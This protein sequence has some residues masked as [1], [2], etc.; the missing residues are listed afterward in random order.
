MR[1][2]SLRGARLVR[3]LTPLLMAASFFLLL[4]VLVP[5]IGMSANGAQRWIGAGLFQIQPSELAKLSLVLY[6][7][8]LLAARPQM[9]RDIR[10]LVPYLLPVALACLL[11]V[12]EPD[13]GTAIVVCL[14][15]GAMLVAAGVKIRHL[16]L[17]AGAIG[18]VLL[19]AIVIEPYRMQR[20]TGFIHPTGDPGGAG[21]QAIQAKIALGSGGIFGVGLGQ[22]LQKAFYLP[23]AHTDMIAAVIG[24]ELGL[25]GL[26]MLV[27]LFGLFGYAG[28]RTAQRARD[29]YGKLLAAGL[30]SLILVQAI[31]NLFAVLGL[32]PA[33]GR[34]AA[35]RL[36]RQLEP[37]GDAGG[38]RA[39]PEH[40]PRGPGCHG[41][42]ERP[43]RCETAGRRRRPRANAQRRQARH[44]KERFAAVPR[45]VIA[46]G[47]TAGHVVPALAVADALRGRG[48]EVSFL[49]ARGRLEAELVPA[50]GYEIDFL[51]VRGLDR[52]APL[53]AAA[54]AALAA[55][56]VPAARTALR[57]RQAEAVMGGG[58]YVAGPAGL[59]ALS[60][61][62]PLVLTEAD[63]HLGLA[64]RLLARGARRV[65]LAFPI[66]G[67]DEGRYMV[68]GRPVPA[69]I[70]AAD[71]EGA[72]RRFQ[73]RAGRPL[74]AR[75]RRQPGRPLDQPLR[76]R[77]LRRGR[78]RGLSARLPRHPDRGPPRLP[79]GPAAAER[80]RRGRAIHAAR[81]R[82]DARR[83]ACRLRPR[84]RPGGRLGVRARGRGQAGDP[85]PLPARDGA[86]PR[87]QRG[88]DV[89]GGRGAGDRRLPARSGHPASNG[90]GPVRGPRSPGEDVRGLPGS[91]PAGRRGAHRRAGARRG[92]AA[93]SG[94][95]AAGDEHRAMTDWSRRKLH[96]IAIGGAGMSGLALVCHRLG[97]R[98]SGSR[99]RPELLPR[100]PDG[101]QAS[102]RGLVTTPTTCR[103]TPRWWS[104]PPFREDNPELARAR[105]RG[106][107]VIHRGELLAELCATKRLLAIAGTHGKTTTAGMLVHA[108]RAIGRRPVLSA[109]RRAAGRRRGWRSRQRRLGRGAS[110]WS[111]RRTSPTRASCAC[112]RRSRW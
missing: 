50:A 75:V 66:P 67:R 105:E 99:S 77:R 63:R 48:A 104:R 47:G 6:G 58:G 27:G 68:T 22:S 5:G 40:R 95:R 26:S 78:R 110:G 55:A 23:E 76:A 84:A 49:G 103:R 80:R 9:T 24:E 16:M 51:R 70:L 20:L 29:R 33:D 102:S 52:R 13:L 12:A 15:T 7:A 14:T 53:K 65:C 81:V 60:A 91:R 4:A 28:L 89:G 21:F 59:A 100:A 73:D 101:R 72:R 83:P 107:R 3:P 98:V 79:A 109:R 32:A 19:L 93:R 45:V 64:N 25:A 87:R 46:A 97:A 30:T 2:L 42:P 56:A 11:M 85:G 82:A 96:F 92:S 94:R 108:L 8:H 1:V 35:V 74:P 38:D 69:A 61:R 41:R 18:V 90:G 17:L 37:P 86:P 54:A 62:L 44:R 111:P 71:R 57:R 39:A 10:G 106:Q 31:V 43:R 88:M 36:L 112:A 34:A